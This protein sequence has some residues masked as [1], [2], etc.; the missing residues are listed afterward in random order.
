MGISPDGVRAY[1]ESDINH[2]HLDVVDNAALDILG[3]AWFAPSAG[4]AREIPYGGTAR[5]SI[6]MVAH[7]QRLAEHEKAALARELHDELG[8]CLISAV[9][10]LSILSPRFAALGDDA[11]EKIRRLALAAETSLRQVKDQLHR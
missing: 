6:R 8:G 3:L 2:Q 7:F 10:D 11:K 4:V 1:E 5:Y 9:M